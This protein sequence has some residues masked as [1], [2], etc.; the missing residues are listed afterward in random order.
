MSTTT[1]RNSVHCTNT[2]P[3]FPSE[4]PQAI[5]SEGLAKGPYEAARAGV[6]SMTIWTKGVDSTNAL[7]TPT[8]LMKN[9]V[10]LD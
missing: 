7:H 10:Q 5:V 4:A 6:K 9:L 3:G 2:V 8:I 1:Q